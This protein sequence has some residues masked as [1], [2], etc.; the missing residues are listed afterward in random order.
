L[1]GFSGFVEAGGTGQLVI[2]GGIDEHIDKYSTVARARGLEER[3]SFI[4]QQPVSRMASLFSA[5]DVLVSP[6]TEGVNTPMKIYSYLASGKPVLATSIASHTQVLSDETA[7]LTA[8]NPNQLTNGMLAL[9]KDEELRIRLGQ[10]GK[11]LADEKYSAKAF[12][13][14]LRDLYQWIERS[15]REDR[16]N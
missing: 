9:A 12:R 15:I 4:G 3:V 13:Q 7:V 14:T 8:P 10:R 5:A 11:A 1:D 6:R 2:A 16:Q